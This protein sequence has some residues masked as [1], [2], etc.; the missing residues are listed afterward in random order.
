MSTA[1]LLLCICAICDKRNMNVS[2]QL[3]P[4]YIGFVVLNIGICFGHNCGYAINPA[5]DLGPRLFTLVAGW[6]TDTFEYKNH[7]WVVPVIGTHVGA[8]IGAVLYSLLV[9]NHWPK[10]EEEEKRRRRDSEEIRKFLKD[11][12]A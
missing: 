8:C 9:E 11:E 7:W 2:S 5:R 10:E 3:S 1:L 6:G 12:L 4:L